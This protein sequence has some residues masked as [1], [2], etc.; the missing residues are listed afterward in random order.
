V[1]V[2]SPNGGPDAFDSAVQELHA[3]MAGDLIAVDYKLAKAYSLG[4]RLAWLTQWPAGG[5]KLE[6]ADGATDVSSLADGDTVAE[7]PEALALEAA[8][9]TMPG[10]GRIEKT[11]EQLGD[12]ATVLPKHASRSVQL[13]L[14]AWSY[15]NECRAQR[16][17]LLT[18]NEAPTLA[19]QGE[20]WRSLLSAEKAG[21]DMLDFTD[22]ESAADRCSSAADRSRASS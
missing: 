3:E 1:P 15:W 6:L 16:A 20:L 9:P 5:W 10:S 13:S 2:A 8:E 11:I 7:T 12:L 19:R 14:G 4:A 22:Y 17:R 21:R 18:G